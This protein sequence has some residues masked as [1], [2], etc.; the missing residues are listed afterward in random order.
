MSDKGINALEA[1]LHG[2][3]P[4][5]LHPLTDDQLIDL[6]DAIGHARRRQAAELAA[7]GDQ[8]LSRIPR[9]LRG[10]LRKALG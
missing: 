5:G 4:G 2:P 6:A 7:A 3:V 9:V 8:A 1:Q 10:P